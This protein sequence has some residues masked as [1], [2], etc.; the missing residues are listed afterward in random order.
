MSLRPPRGSGRLGRMGARPT[1]TDLAKELGVSPSTVSRALRDHPAISDS[2]KAEVWAAAEALGLATPEP[3]AP[4]VTPGRLL[5]VVVPSITHPFFASVIEKL[6]AVC[7][8][9]EAE[10]IVH[11]TGGQAA[12]EP[13]I[14]RT[15]VRRQV[16]GVIFVPTSPDLSSL[17]DCQLQLPTVVITQHPDSVPSI[18]VNHA[19]GGG[20]AAEHFQELGRSSCLLVGPKNDEKFQGFR[21]YLETQRLTGF[22]VEQLEVDGWTDSLSLG[23]RRALLDQYT[24]VSVKHF[25]C[26]FAFNDLAA[27]GVL[28]GL[29]ELGVRVPEDIA[30]CGFDD[31]PLAREFQPAL[32]SLAQPVGQIV[33][34][35]YALL[36]RVI[37]G[38]PPAAGERVLTLRPHLV[39]R[40]STFGGPD[41]S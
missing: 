27:F 35:G 33:R 24:S 17:E 8:Q 13:S 22:R 5:S 18:G 16:D 26:V 15:L 7:A 14:V 20:M 29:Q 39:V 10:L 2:R 23:A 40:A 3:A 36:E 30:V 28:H 11:S 37:A 41:L 19:E 9:H 21:A 31:T 25:D 1:I 12:L 34:S 32:T 38:N 6:E 4:P